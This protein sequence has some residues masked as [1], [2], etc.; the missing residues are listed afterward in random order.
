MNK[1]IAEWS[2]EGVDLPKFDVDRMAEYTKENPVWIHF[3]AGN[4]FRGFIASIQQE[5]LNK[6]LQKSGII[7]SDT[8]DYEIIDKIY[9]P[10]DNKTLLAL[11]HADGS[12]EKEIVASVAEAVP[13]DSSSVDS[14]RRLTEI[15]A[16]PSL[17]VV[18][19]TITEKGYALRGI[20]GNLFPVVAS[21]IENGPASP[22]HAMSVVTSLALARYN[23][24]KFPVSFAS[25]DNC[26]HNG[27]KLE[28][29]VM[30]IAKE[31]VKKG[32]AE[33]G[34]IDYLTDKNGVA[35]PWSMIDKITPRPSPIVQKKLED[36]GFTNMSPVITN[37]KTYIAPFV[38]AEVS[39]Y[40]VIEDS[41]PNGRPQF[42][43]AGVYMTD[44]T[45][46]NR[47][48]Q[49]K[50]T[51]CLNPLH[52]ALAVYGCML[53]FTSIADEMK[54]EVL[55]KLIKKIGYDEGL[56]VVVDPKIL[57]PKDF[58]D[59]V[60]NVR[61]PNP[62]IPDT[63]QR[64][65]SDTSQKIPVRY[66]E[67]IKSY[68]STGKDLNNL[69]GIP[70]AIAGWLRYLLAKDDSGSNFALS[71]DPMAEE[72]QP[73]VKSGNLHSILSNITIFGTDLYTTPLASKIENLFKEE[74]AGN[75]AVMSTLKK[76]LK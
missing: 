29:A 53:G 61:L 18:S 59:E 27:E 56:P 43:E 10:Y 21:D 65:A 5:L 58:I 20:D 74:C 52:T 70:L 15:F 3:G 71:P 68:I 49:M 51:T 13:A 4:I 31:W 72:L 67:T 23:C 1:Q 24:G 33:E 62:N 35:F 38:N 28:N 12:L 14:W 41:F 54:N 26:S 39:H 42:E 22:K 37:K 36:L 17:Q 30:F 66:G 34:F 19:F 50:V 76:Y 8:F 44:R 69:I 25:M 6:G 47:S 75:G 7:A 9:K 55:V 16:S 11:M 57:N 48:E 60:V 32:F 40:L 73:I 64:I 46:V 45:T 63:P 2:K